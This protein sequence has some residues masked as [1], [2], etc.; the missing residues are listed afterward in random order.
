VPYVRMDIRR[1][2]RHTDCETADTSFTEDVLD[3]GTREVFTAPFV[4][5]IYA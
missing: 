5:T 2:A 1:T 3:H 4:A